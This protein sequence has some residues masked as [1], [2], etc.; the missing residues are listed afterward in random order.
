MTKWIN[1]YKDLQVTK[2]RL[3]AL[4]QMARINPL[5]GLSVNEASQ[6][7]AVI[8]QK[9][10][11]LDEILTSIIHAPEW[12]SAPRPNVDGIVTENDTMLRHFGE[13]EIQI[14][15]LQSL[16]DDRRLEIMEELGIEEQFV[17]GKR[18]LKRKRAND[19]SAAP[20]DEEESKKIHHRMDALEDDIDSIRN[21]LNQHDQD[22]R[23][24]IEQ[25]FE[26]RIAD[27]EAARK[28]P[29]DPEV[30]WRKTTTTRLDKLQE[31]MQTVS[32]DIQ[33]LLTRANNAET[34]M[35]AIAQATQ[36][37]LLSNQAVS[38]TVPVIRFWSLY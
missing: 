33:N 11:V 22:F 10:A 27:V 9:Q 34:E 1:Q 2:D 18:P 6:F 38:P 37:E 19:S 35:S 26:A 23:D 25:M 8:Q 29:N 32:Q 3:E 17:D 31:S 5:L 21:S 12:P 24:D 16:V 14:A 30:K 28:S 15:G 36:Q 4:H 20:M 7:E 13:L